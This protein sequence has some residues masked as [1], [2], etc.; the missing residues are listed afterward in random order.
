MSG[1][2]HGW[3]VGR[4]GRGG[5]RAGGRSGGRSRVSGPRAARGFTLVEVLLAVALT[6]VLGAALASALMVAARA[7]P[8]PNAPLARVDGAS[9]ALDELTRDLSEAIGVEGGTARAM[10]FTVPDRDGDAAAER[11]VYS[12]DGKAGSPLVRT[13]NDRPEELVASVEQFSLSYETIQAM[14]PAPVAGSEQSLASFDSGPS[15]LTSLTSSNSAGQFFRPTLPEGAV[16]WSLSQM[17]FSPRVTSPTDGQLLVRVQRA[18]ASGLPTGAVMRQVAMSES[19]LGAAVSLLGLVSIT[20]TS[21][22]TL[23]FDPPIT[24]LR[25]GEGVCV[26]FVHQS[27]GDAGRLELR[28]PGVVTAGAHRLVS[29]DRGATW[30]AAP[31]SMLVTQFFGV[32]TGGAET[33]VGPERLSRVGVTLAPGSGTPALRGAVVLL[34]APEVP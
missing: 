31:G 6:G 22:R 12:W 4:V 28:T 26:L 15:T 3:R 1:R 27:G 8:G 30:A 20:S 33:L 21:A 24:G 14:G 23:V 25:P 34:N 10:A 19:S 29:G 13:L 7:A 32:V 5:W 16:E 17:I 11:L 2:A 18:D 9:A